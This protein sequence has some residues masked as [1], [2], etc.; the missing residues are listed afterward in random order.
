[1][2]LP[3]EIPPVFAEQALRS[4]DWA[5]YIRQLPRLADELTDEWRLVYDGQPTYGRA[6]LVL[7]V[8]TD[9][10]RRAV[11]KLGYIH[12]DGAGEPVALQLWG[13]NG[14]VELWAADPRRGA[15]LL[16]RLGADDL[17]SLDV[18]EACGVVGGLYGLIHRAP[19]PRLTDLRVVVS[20]WLDD[21]RA[22]PRDAVPSRFVE[23]ALAAAPRLMGDEPSAVIH[24]DL[25]Y[26]NVLRG[27]RR[28]WLVIDPKGFAGDPAYEL[29]PMLWNRWP[30][31]GDEPGV[32][33]RDRFFALVE[34]SGLD[35]RRCRDWVVVRAVINVS[36]EYVA[37]AGRPLSA[38]QRE[39]TTRGITTAKAMQDI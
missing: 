22:L 27:E 10:D 1:V 25:H 16:E 7:P 15:L 24:G 31:L 13:G 35:E 30:E 39:W 3:Y 28:P 19:T 26:E 2:K 6:G 38:A 17:T 23:Q 36:W 33:I 4:D 11:L 8:V 29:A 18:L 34:A 12:S 21:V 5:A 37:A 9:D 14:A 20:G 32:G